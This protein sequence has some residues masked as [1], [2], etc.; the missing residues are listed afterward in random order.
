MNKHT[1]VCKLDVCA[2]PAS[3]TAKVKP[4]TSDMHTG[5]ATIQY[6]AN[7]LQQ[8]MHSTMTT[9]DETGCRWQA[10]DGRTVSPVFTSYP[11]PFPCQAELTAHTPCKNKR[12]HDAR[13]IAMR[14]DSIVNDTKKMV[15]RGRH[16]HIHNTPRLH[17]TYR[18]RDVTFT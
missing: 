18:S 1:A 9:H 15:R 3:S 5:H 6:A 2:Q 13:H 7:G 12:T 8:A 14:A 16:A 17:S 10:A 11:V 4:N